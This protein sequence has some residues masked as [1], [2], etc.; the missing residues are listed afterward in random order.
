MHAATS[1]LHQAPALP[2][3]RHRWPWLLMAGPAIVVVAGVYTGYLAFR[4]PDALV[5]D[6]YYTRGKAINQDLS[7]DRAASALGLGM[8][9]RLDRETGRLAGAVVGKNGPVTG[10]MRLHL[11][12]A[13]RPEKDLRFLVMANAEGRFAVPLPALENARWQVLLESDAR[14]WRLTGTWR[15]PHDPAFAAQAQTVAT[16]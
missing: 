13:T 11:A 4:Q 15:W 14:D 16:P 2:W 10:P 12:H 8:T 1:P 6:D 9:L 3:Y 7:R 5:V